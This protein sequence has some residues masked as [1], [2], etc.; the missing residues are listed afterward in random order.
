MPSHGLEK[1]HEKALRERNEEAIERKHKRTHEADEQTAK[2]WKQEMTKNKHGKEH[3]AGDKREK[4]RTS[5]EIVVP[6]TN[7]ELMSGKMIQTVNDA[8]K[9]QGNKSLRDLSFKK[10]NVLGHNLKKADLQMRKDKMEPRDII[11]DYTNKIADIKEHA[12]TWE[13]AKD[14]FEK[15]FGSFFV[16]K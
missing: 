4:R 11:T 3:T 14:A 6:P 9:K 12:K 16:H 2:K 7:T 15:S 13:N 8:F 1:A 5:S 10:L